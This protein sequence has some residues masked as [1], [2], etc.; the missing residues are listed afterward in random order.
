MSSRSN[1]TDLQTQSTRDCCCPEAQPLDKQVWDGDKVIQQRSPSPLLSHCKFTWQ[2]LIDTLRTVPPSVQKV[3]VVVDMYADVGEEFGSPLDE[4]PQVWQILRD[5]TSVIHITLHLLRGV[6]VGRMG[7][8]DEVDDY[9]KFGQF[10]RCA[11]DTL[12]TSL[13]DRSKLC[14]LLEPTYSPT[15]APSV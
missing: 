9:K 6:R 13:S 15:H 8:G 1:P 4:W 5:K 11:K 10:L 3:D 12:S 7:R 2:Y 14:S